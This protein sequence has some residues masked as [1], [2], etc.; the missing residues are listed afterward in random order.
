MGN[1]EKRHECDV[2]GFD[3][4]LSRL[5][6]GVSGKQVGL[7]YVCPFCFDEVHPRDTT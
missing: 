5:K 1:R 4:P 3:Y 6:K 7:Q 2:C